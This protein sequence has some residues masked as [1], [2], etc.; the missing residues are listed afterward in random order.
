MSQ[1][2]E[3]GDEF[4]I[5]YKKIYKQSYAPNWQRCSDPDKT[6]IVYKLSKSLGKVYYI[7]NRTNIKCR[8]SR[9]NFKINKYNVPESDKNIADKLKLIDIS[10]V[11]LIKK[12][13]K[14]HRDIVLRN[15]L[16]NI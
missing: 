2:F 1:E 5:D 10:E 4:K 7:D 16:K 12:K 15:I 13:K 9:C 3:I 6:Y 11:N 14:R 8:C